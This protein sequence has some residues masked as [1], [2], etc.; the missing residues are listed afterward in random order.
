MVTEE[1]IRK[2][3]SDWF[4]HLF[5]RCGATEYVATKVGC[6]KQTVRNALRADRRLRELYP[7]EVSALETVEELTKALK[8]SPR[9]V[10][11]ALKE[12]VYEPIERLN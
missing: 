7:A 11:T 9:I 4:A 12:R 5:G 1:N 10:L 3:R 2:I 8:K 6:S